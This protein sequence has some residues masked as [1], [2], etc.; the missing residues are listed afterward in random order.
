M[1]DN[2][3]TVTPAR[4]L[5]SILKEWFGPG[6]TNHYDMRGG[7]YFWTK[8]YPALGMEHW[9]GRETRN[10]PDIRFWTLLG[11]NNERYTT[12]EDVLRAYWVREGGAAYERACAEQGIDA[13]EVELLE[14]PGVDWRAIQR[15]EQE[16]IEKLKAESRAR[17]DAAMAARGLAK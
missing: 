15:A 1:G 9:E 14:A 13:P 8:N 6:Y 5:P 4:T 3:E 12:N 16:R 17:M 2:P 11:C 10:G 7:G